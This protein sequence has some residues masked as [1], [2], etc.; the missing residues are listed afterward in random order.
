M[1]I[2]YSVLTQDHEHN[3]HNVGSDMTASEAQKLVNILIQGEDPNRL[4]DIV[5]SPTIRK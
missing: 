4:A 1:E 3:V 2:K 5:I